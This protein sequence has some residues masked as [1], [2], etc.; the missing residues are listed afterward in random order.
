M[1]KDLALIPISAVALIG[2]VTT[3]AFA[4]T[5]ESLEAEITAM[6]ERASE[7]IVSV[8][9]VTDVGG[10]LVSRSVGCGVVFDRDGLVLTTTSVVGHAKQVDVVSA[11]GTRHRGRV[12]GIDPASDIAVV[13]VEGARMVPAAFTKGRPLRPGSWIFVLGNAFGSLPSVSMGVVS[14]FSSPVRDDMG[15]EMLRISVALNPGDTGAPVVDARG[16]VVGI[17][18][19]RISF[20]PWSSSGFM[21]EG[22]PPGMGFL[23]PSGMSV[24]IPAER[25]I[26][27]AKDIVLTG[28]KERGFLGVRVVEL[29]DDMRSHIGDRALE[30]VVVTEVVASSPAESAG[31]VPGDVI[32]DFATRQVRSVSSLLETVGK[33]KP[34]DVVTVTYIRDSKQ[35]TSDV[36]I[37]PFLSEYLRGQAAGPRV[38]P[39]DVGTRIEDIKSEIERLKADLKDLETKR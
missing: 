2:L 38:N 8:N 32:T 31:I 26:S 27:I 35:L 19:G 10:K 37:S 34:G 15:E 14:G 39:R 5:L 11:S 24:A 6:V 9:A 33:T 29:S 4:Q 25:A 1:R 36:R 30:G 13:K 17:A 21:A 12:V 3:C 18:V 22:A 16:E 23:Q 28:G 7:S 20:N